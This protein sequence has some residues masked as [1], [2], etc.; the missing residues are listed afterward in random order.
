MPELFSMFRV[1]ETA[2]LY[3]WNDV[4][5]GKCLCGYRTEGETVS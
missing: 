3:Y 1:T 2:G 5:S 4:M